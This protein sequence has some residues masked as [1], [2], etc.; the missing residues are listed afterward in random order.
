MKIDC[1]YVGGKNLNGIEEKNFSFESVF[2]LRF[3]CTG[4]VR[5]QFVCCARDVNHGLF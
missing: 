3:D 1:D 2:R 4:K 5:G